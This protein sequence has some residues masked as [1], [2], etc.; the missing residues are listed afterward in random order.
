M[1]EIAESPYDGEE[2]I[3]AIDYVLLRDSQDDAP[4]NHKQRKQFLKLL[5]EQE[6]R[7][8]VYSVLESFGY[9]VDYLNVP[10]D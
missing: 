6:K 5:D 2:F 7:G 10:N 3:I 8:L 4:L 1:I 9:V